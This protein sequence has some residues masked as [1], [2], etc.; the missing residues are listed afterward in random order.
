MPR[1]PAPSR[2][3]GRL[4]DETSLPLYAIDDQ[5]RVLFANSACCEW[6]GISADDLIGRQCNYAAGGD[7]PLAP[8]CGALCPPPEA[9]AGELDHGEICR[10]AFGDRPFERRPAIFVR[11]TGSDGKTVAVLVAIPPNISSEI[12]NFKSSSAETLHSL[13]I[14]LRGDFGKR[15]HISQ[16]IGA[17]DATNRVREQVRIAADSGARAVIIGPP[18]SGR[19]HVARTIHYS[20]PAESIGPL[21]PIDCRLVDAEQMQ[22]QLTSLLR[23]Q[24]EHPTERPPAALLLEVDRLK[25]TAQQELAGF[26]QLPKIELKTLAT[27]R[28]SLDKLVAKG[29]FRSDLAN[30]LSTLVIRLPSLAARRADI[31]L[32]A[33]HFLELQNAQSPTQL[34]GFQSAALELLLSLPWKNNLDQL[35]AAVEAACSRT[36][37]PRVAVAD[38]PDWVH[39]AKDDA[40]RA[41][42]DEE[43]IQLDAFLAEIEKELLL[44]AMRRA[45][46]N[47]SRAAA[48]LGLS[49]QRLIRRLVQLGLAPKPADE[50]VI[51]EPLPEES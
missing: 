33:Q 11:L 47:K 17:S 18:G 34:S 38:F 39:L 36:T 13:L 15:Y 10:A 45:R 32:L 6:L 24:H 8:L 48:L 5:R 4:L 35:A 40:A 14:K 30:R 49:R 44:R 1:P 46:G 43:P 31:P 50:P 19:E 25:S 42:R 2:L 16:L 20:Q 26:L 27:S 29:K 28:V 22:A 51:F 37:G 3:L 7:E 23:G 41:P 21:V 12:S 9:F